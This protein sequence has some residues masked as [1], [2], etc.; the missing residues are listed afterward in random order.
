MRKKENTNTAKHSSTD[1]GLH[2]KEHGHKCIPP[3]HIGVGLTKKTFKHIALEEIHHIVTVY[4][5]FFLS[6]SA[7]G[8]AVL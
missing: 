3:K 2:N 8:S 1:F 5:F 4:L 7:Q 6:F